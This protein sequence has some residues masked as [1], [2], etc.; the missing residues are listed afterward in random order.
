MSP[1]GAETRSGGALVLVDEAA[2]EVEPVQAGYRR[3]WVASGYHGGARLGRLEVERAV[4]PPAVVAAHL[5]AE[6]TLELA[7]ADNQEPV[8]AL[9]ADAA[10]PALDVGVRVRR[11]ARR[12]GRSGYLRR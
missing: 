3:R 8:E 12:P 2:E 9:T 5:H 1:W 6:H 11:P 7:A 10:D 4:R